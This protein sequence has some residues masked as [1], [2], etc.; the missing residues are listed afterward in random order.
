MTFQHMPV[1]GAAK[2]AWF[3]AFIA[4][5]IAPSASAGTTASCKT[6]DNR[7]TPQRSFEY[8]RLAADAMTAKVRPK[9]VR[10]LQYIQS[11]SWSAVYVSTP[12]S[13]DGMMFFLSN[14][15]TKQFKGVWGGW[16]TPDDRKELISWAE[17]IG[18]PPTLA[19]CFADSVTAR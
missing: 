3:A 11:G 5:L 18:A 2:V 1:K 6:L 14:G 15:K 8:A 16:A 12:V 9:D 10:I 4:I 19:Q 13:E 17:G 7:L